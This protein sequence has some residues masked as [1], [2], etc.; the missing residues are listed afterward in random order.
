MAVTI[1]AT[2]NFS[3]GLNQTSLTFSH[4]CTGASVIVIMFVRRAVSESIKAVS[5]VTYDGV[6]A[7]LI[8]Q[9]TS[10]DNIA[11]IYALAAPSAG[12]NDVVITLASS[13]RVFTASAVSLIGASAVADITGGTSGSGIPSTAVTTTV[14]GSMVL[15]CFQS[16][17]NSN[18]T[19]GASQT[20]IY[21]DTLNSDRGASSYESTVSAGSVTM[22]WTD[23][24]SDN[25]SQAV[26]AF[27]PSAG[28]AFLIDII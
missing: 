1:D 17:A 5:S 22:N 27:P 23:G 18:F 4:T 6:S 2:S 14:G 21:Q 16:F 8:K 3:N 9:E 24:A 19:V 15:D 20:Q 12:A 11:E 7:S 25:F 28:G 26:A 13:Q 10:G